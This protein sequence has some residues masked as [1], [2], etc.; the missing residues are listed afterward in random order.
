M[1][2]VKNYLPKSDLKHGEYYNG[3][4]RNANT[5]RW[6]AETEEFI[7]LRDKTGMRVPEVM[8]Y[9]AIKHPEDFRGVDVFFPLELVTWGVDAIP[10]EQ[11]DYETFQSRSK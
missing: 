3:T 10:L 1:R 6:N 8:W 2:D 4:C 11:M 5:A 9:E 7:H